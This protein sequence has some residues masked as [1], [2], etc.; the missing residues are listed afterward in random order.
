MV[1]DFEGPVF[2]GL[3]RESGIKPIVE[4]SN[5]E[6]LTNWRLSIVGQTN[7]D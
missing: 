5:G 1:I 6:I 3:D 7:G 2:K 4:A